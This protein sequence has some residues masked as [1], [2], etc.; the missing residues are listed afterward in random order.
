MRNQ[1]KKKPKSRYGY[2]ITDAYY[3]VII[4]GRRFVIWHYSGQPLQGRIEA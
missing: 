4:R 2:A 3:A 1:K